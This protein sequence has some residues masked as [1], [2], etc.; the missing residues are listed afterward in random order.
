MKKEEVTYAWLDETL[1]AIGLIFTKNRTHGTRKEDE[2]KKIV[3]E[4]SVESEMT[5]VT[6]KKG[7]VYQNL[8]ASGHSPNEV[9]QIIFKKMTESDM[10]LIGTCENYK[11]KVI[12]ENGSFKRITLSK[13]EVLDLNLPY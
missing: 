6:L 7:A 12:L 1:T 3:I 9:A 2:G 5:P 4:A 11:E 13:D 10:V 8:H